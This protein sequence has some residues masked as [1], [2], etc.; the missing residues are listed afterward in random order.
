[1]LE[2]LTSHESTFLSTYAF[3]NKKNIQELYLRLERFKQKSRN[4]NNEM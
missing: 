4:P 2:M 1:M 3:C